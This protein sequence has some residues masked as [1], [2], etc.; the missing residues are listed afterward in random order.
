ML[1]IGLGNP[2]R[3]YEKTRHNA[4]FFTVDR[5]ASL[6]G[7]VFRK[8]VFKKY[9]IAEG[10]YRD[11]RVILVKPLTFMNRSGDIIAGLLD[12]YKIDTRNMVLVCDNMD[13]YPGVIRLKLSGGDAGHNGI[14][15]VINRLDASDFKRLYIGIGRPEKS[16]RIVEHVLGVPEVKELEKIMNAASLASEK[17]L[18]LIDIPAEKVMNEINRIKNIP[19]NSCC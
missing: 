17:I 15:S 16:S 9:L 4:G 13:L 10:V 11:N 2:G 7:A 5:I 1:I 12:K 19:D 18:E 6:T 14:K 8:P 3:K